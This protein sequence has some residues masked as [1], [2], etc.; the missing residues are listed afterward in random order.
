MQDMCST[1]WVSLEPVEY[2]WT[3]W[4]GEPEGLHIKHGD[5]PVTVKVTWTD[6]TEGEVNAWT[7]QWTH[8]HVASIVGSVDGASQLFDRDFRP[9]SDRARA[10]LSSILVARR[11]DEPLPPIEV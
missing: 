11:Q 4:G 1:A 5:I 10:R 7:S 9:V 8:T 2:P 6:G 3:R